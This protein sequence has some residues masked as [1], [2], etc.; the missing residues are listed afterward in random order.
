MG[1]TGFFVKG[2]AETEISSHEG[3]VAEACLVV[4]EVALHFE[5]S[6]LRPPTRPST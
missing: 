1:L 2:I 3:R 5:A 6:E 4:E